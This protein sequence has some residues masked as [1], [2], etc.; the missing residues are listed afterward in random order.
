MVKKTGATA[1]SNKAINYVFSSNGSVNENWPSP[2]TK[3]S[4]DYVLATTKNSNVIT[5]ATAVIYRILLNA[6]LRWMMAV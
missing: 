5:H 1:L 2:Y 3:K 4:V 6:V